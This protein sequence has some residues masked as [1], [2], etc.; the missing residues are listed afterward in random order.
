ML[1]YTTLV[2]SVSAY[3][4]VCTLSSQ[5]KCI[6]LVHSRIIQYRI[7]LQGCGCQSLFTSILHCPYQ[8]MC[9]TGSNKWAK[10]LINWIMLLASL[11]SPLAPKSGGT[12][13][14]H[15][16]RICNNRVNGARERESLPSVD[17]NILLSVY[18]SDLTDWIKQ[19]QY[20]LSSLHSSVRS[21]CLKDDNESL[22]TLSQPC[23]LRIRIILS[24]TCT[25]ALSVLS[26][27]M[28][29]KF[30]VSGKQSRMG[31]GSVCMI[32]W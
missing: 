11:K 27:I 23:C 7:Q 18:W 22:I 5:A 28:C 1:V 15:E 30:S 14:S 2:H 3:S 6:L 29:V 16:W 13:F 26:L 32:Y 24:G 12:E 31:T 19:M 8:L 20:L 4:E 25:K 10:D 9:K 17:P 21:I